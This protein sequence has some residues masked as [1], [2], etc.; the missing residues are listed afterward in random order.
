MAQ[1]FKKSDMKDKIIGRHNEKLI[2]E[3][4][5]NSGSSEFVAIYGRRRVGKTFLVREFFDNDFTFQLSGL[6]NSNIKEQLLNFNMTLKRYV[7]KDISVPGSWIEAFEQLIDYI[8]TCPSGRKIIFLDE[9]PWLDTPYSNFIQAFEHFWNGW[10]SARHDI[11]M[12]VCGSA[13]S[14][15][16]DKLINN[17]GGLHNR[18][19]YKMRLEPFSLKECEEF[20]N[21]REIELN[22]YQIAECYMVMGGIPYY[23]NLIVK[24]LSIY[25]NIDMLFFA[26]NAQ[27]RNE[28]ENLY[29]SLFKNSYNYI[30]VVEALSK[31]NKG[32]SRKEITELT[33]IPTSGNLSTILKNLENC[34]FIRSYNAFGKRERDKLYQL[35]DF[36][37]LFY[38]KYIKAN[39]YN[40][41]MFWTNSIDTPLHNSWAG[42]AYEMLCL[43]HIKQIK[44][45]LG[46]SGVQSNVSA[47]RSTVSGNGAQIDL[48]IDRKDQTINVCE[49]KFSTENYSIT[50]AYEENLRNKI[51]SFRQETKTKKA[52]HLTLITTYG[53]TVN[54][55][56]GMVQKEVVFEDLFNI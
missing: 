35:T 13:T 6:A 44:N 53:L 19:T 28:F 12:I 31:K 2:L 33:K 8:E 36:Y 15:I 48:L 29:A 7:N 39:E 17:H 45:A 24:G 52:I 34:G 22:R 23:L 4:L 3:R 27:L 10:A 5:Y 46:I 1:H 26:E 37:T 40:D 42:Y 11:L 32:L 38:F 14:W 18:L 51:S 25:Q 9:L 21:H 49:I 50:K 41:D 56:S 20:F 54:K 43:N 16:T 55:Y 47:W 30:K